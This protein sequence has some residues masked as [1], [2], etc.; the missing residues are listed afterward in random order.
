MK[1]ILFTL[2]ISFLCIQLLYSQEIHFS[3]IKNSTVTL[4]PALVGNSKYDFKSQLVYRSQFETFSKA[5][6]TI[7]TNTEISVLDNNTGIFCSKKLNVGISYAYDK[8]GSLNL[9]TSQLNLSLSYSPFLDKKYYLD[10]KQDIHSGPLTYP[11][12]KL[13]VNF[14]INMNPYI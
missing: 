6:T 5:Y 12:H 13:A 4:N 14:I 10:Y 9:N 7:M 8:A 2:F 3:D 1:L 11:K